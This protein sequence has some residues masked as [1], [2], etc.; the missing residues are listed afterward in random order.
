MMT[1]RFTAR[2]LLA[3]SPLVFVTAC[4]FTPSEDWPVPDYGD[5]AV[6]L[7]NPPDVSAG[8]PTVL[9]VAP[10]EAV[11]VGRFVT[12]AACKLCHSNNAAATAM[13]DAAGNDLGPFNRWQGTMM[14][15]ASRDPFWR[16]AVSVEMANT[17]AKAAEIEQKCIRC[18]APMAS[19]TSK[20]SD[21]P[22]S[23]DWATRGSAGEAQVFADGVACTVCHQILPDGLGIEG[24][25]SGNFAIG[26]DREIFGPHRNP[27]PGPMQN[28]V[29]YTPT[30]GDHVLEPGLCAT[31]HTLETQALTSDGA[32]VE[33]AA[34]LEQSPFLEW[35]VSSFWNED[36]A[37]AITCQDCHMPTVDEDGNIIQTRIARSP[38][39]GDFNIQE[40]MPFGRHVFVGAN[41]AMPNLIK[42]E[43]AVL[44][45][46][47]TDG[48]FDE[49]V[50]L[51]R[52]RLREDTA[53]L[54]IDDVDI[55]TSNGTLRFGV[56]IESMV[57][58]KLPTGFPSRRVFL[59]VRIFGDD[60][61]LL[62]ESGAFDE[63]GQLIANGEVLDVEKAG[64]PIE[65]HH[66][67]IDRPDQVAIFEQV[68]RD[69]NGDQTFSLMRA[70][71]HLKDNRLLPAGASSSKRGFDRIA[72]V[73][74]DSD[75]DFRGGGDVVHFEVQPGDP[76]QRIAVSLHYQGL[77][78]RFLRELFQNDTA[79]VRAFR[80]MLDDEDVMPEL[81][82]ETS[83]DL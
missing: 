49:V 59:R 77:S 34:Y 50:A 25:F 19:V 71:G 65:A 23:M 21:V 24:T 54:S 78:P 79:E 73:G 5:L 56:R 82:A 10:L 31:C 6:G 43:R 66:T 14:A 72:P 83:T 27:A 38:P 30:Y 32:P 12:S 16:A 41:T 3:L 13:R 22:V 64:G 81:I 35:K 40:R 53:E 52:Q 63:R 4:P 69:R 18:H 61:R 39:G 48:A 37:N 28:H 15:N 60:D 44:N 67:V 58:H 75:R 62:F 20:D 45:P 47:A 7:E 9:T 33:G 36:R 1:D 8:D 70:T 74:T 17:P 80:A 51:A 55:D 2:L 68:M 11:G 46:Q 42:R 57:G 29:N 76:P 26:I